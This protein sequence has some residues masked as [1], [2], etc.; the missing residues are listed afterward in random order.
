MAMKI[1]CA[2]LFVF[3]LSLVGCSND[4]MPP[5]ENWDEIKWDQNNWS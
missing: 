3:S 2:L 4:E 1:L 5:V